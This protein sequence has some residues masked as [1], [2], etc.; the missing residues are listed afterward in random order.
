MSSRPRPSGP[1]RS[2]PATCLP[3][4][5]S[6]TDHGQQRPDRR[7]PG[8]ARRPPRATHPAQPHPGRAHRRPRRAHRH[9]HSTPPTPT[10]T[11]PNR[12]RSGGTSRPTDEPNPSPGSAPGSS[13]STGPA[14]G[15]WP[16]RSARAGKRTTCACTRWT[17]RP[18]SGRSCTCS[19]CGPRSC[20]PPRPNTRPASCPPWPTSSR[21]KSSAAVTPA[22]PHWLAPRRGAGHD[23]RHSPPGSGLRHLRLAGPALP[24]GQ[25]IPATPHGYRDATTDPEQINDW[26]GRHPDWNLAI[27]TGA[28]G[29]DVLDVD[30]HGPAGNGY[31]AFRRLRAAG[32]LDGAAIYVRTPSG[33][34]HAYFTGSSQRN[35]HLPGHH[36]DF[37]SRGGY[38]LTPPSQID[39]QPYQ[40]IEQPGGRG[41][42][43]W[44]AVTR[45]LQPQRQPLRRS[46][47]SPR[48]PTTT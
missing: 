46:P 36:L 22:A 21:P 33:G 41:G 14:T 9:H 11:S 35:G 13:R 19:P 47:G 48:P 42:L 3:A 25:K 38:V 12:R 17:S 32:L 5:S 44:A 6:G 20:C 15:T 37:R 43:D 1:N 45:L 27:V 18:A 34:L 23:R 16:P 10:A 26:F 29:P 4:P 40:L 8:P 28:P 31:P 7:D 39:G 2:S 24:P 30:D